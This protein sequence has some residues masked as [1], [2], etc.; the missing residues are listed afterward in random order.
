MLIKILKTTI[1]LWIDSAM[2]F[3][4]IAQICGSIGIPGAILILLIFL[5]NKHAPG[6][7]NHLTGMET[8]LKILT[9]SI[10]QLVFELKRTN[11]CSNTKKHDDS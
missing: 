1:R 2:D 4:A 7:I 9:N 5:I 11:G 6:L 8:Q 10:N 3:Q